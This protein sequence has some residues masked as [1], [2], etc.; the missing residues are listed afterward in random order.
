MDC[1]VVDWISFR[2]FCEQHHCCGGRKKKRTVVKVKTVYMWK[3]KMRGWMNEARCGVV[4]CGVVMRQWEVGVV[5]TSRYGC[6]TREGAVDDQQGWKKEEE[7]G[8]ESQ[9][10]LNRNRNRDMALVVL[11]L[12][13]R[14]DP[15]S[16]HFEIVHGVSRAWMIL[17]IVL[18]QLH[19][20]INPIYFPVFP[21][22]PPSKKRQS[23]KK[24][25]KF[26]HSLMPLPSIKTVIMMGRRRQ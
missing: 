16:F 18:L 1:C 21:N 2:V 15:R 19:Y 13:V 8:D 17:W 24:I 11:L 14:Q 6:R 23:M 7:D 20:I 10:L 3:S 22:H 12:S 9:S 4:W 25:H 5:A 26:K